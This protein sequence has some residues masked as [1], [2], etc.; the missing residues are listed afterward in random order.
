MI[1][2]KFIISQNYNFDN[3]DKK[4][5]LKKVVILYIKST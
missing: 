1:K 2:N 5:T 4:K 3:F